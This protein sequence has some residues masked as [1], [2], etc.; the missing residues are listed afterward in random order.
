MANIWQNIVNF[1][2]HVGWKILAGLCILILGAFL[3]VVIIKTI[4]KILYRMPIETSVVTFITSIL[5][6][7]LY[8]I[9]FFIFAGVLELSTSGF[10]VALSSLALAIGLALKDSLANLANGVFIIYNKPFKRGDEININGVEGK[11][12]NIKLLCTELI[13]Y[14]NKKLIIPNSKFT[15]E[16]IINYTAIPTRRVEKK[17]GVAYGTDL[18]LVEKVIKE[19]IRSCPLILDTPTPSVFL[20]N[21]NESSLD[22]SV[23]VWVKTDNYWTVYNDL[24]RLIYDAFHKNHIEIPFK[25]LDVHFDNPIALSPVKTEKSKLELENTMSEKLDENHTKTPKTEQDKIKIQNE[26]IKTEKIKREENNENN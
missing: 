5:K 23:K 1:F 18:D 15:T 19:T 6:I 16:T 25:Q 17:F 13:T 11:V 22:Y 3:I 12:Q 26:K 8:I 7:V 21:H 2:D 20:S 24:P 4:K 10:I 9:L 14:D